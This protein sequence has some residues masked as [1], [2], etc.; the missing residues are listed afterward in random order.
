M[1]RRHSPGRWSGVALGAPDNV[2]LRGR[3][4]S[5][6]AVNCFTRVSAEG[7]RIF[8]IGRQREYVTSFDFT[9]VLRN[10]CNDPNY[11]EH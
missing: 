10:K 4:S 7:S 8:S 6:H 2:H 9:T 5:T 3:V 1:P 11:Y